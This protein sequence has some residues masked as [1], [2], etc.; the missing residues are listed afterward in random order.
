MACMKAHG[1]EAGG[2]RLSREYVRR[3]DCLGGESRLEP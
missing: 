3:A 1:W 2:G